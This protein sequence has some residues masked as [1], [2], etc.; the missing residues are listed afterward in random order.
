MCLGDETW[1]RPQTRYRYVLSK[2]PQVNKSSQIDWCLT[3]KKTLY[4]FDIY[5]RCLD[6]FSGFWHTNTS[7]ALTKATPAAG[8]CH[9]KHL[10][11]VS[12]Q[13]IKRDAQENLMT[14]LRLI[15]TALRI[16]S[17][18]SESWHLL[19]E[20]YC[21]HIFHPTPCRNNYYLEQFIYFVTQVD[22][23]KWPRGKPG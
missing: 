21:T 6:R 19:R 15:A 8:P 16:T 10:Y 17:V 9:I 12:E 2:S 1:Q 11:F 3:A 7:V 4:W 5:R 13:W 22:F 20:N 14:H 18:S 23:E